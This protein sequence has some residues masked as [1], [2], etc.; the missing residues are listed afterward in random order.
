MSIKVTLSGGIATVLLDRADKLNALSGEMYH[1]FADA[2]G[3]LNGDVEK[4]M[5][6]CGLGMV[7]ADRIE[8]LAAIVDRL[9]T[10]ARAAMRCLQG[11]YQ[12]QA[13]FHNPTDHT[14]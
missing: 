10:E 5:L 9:E 2:F 11:I 8:A 13:L 12:S 7:F 14:G 1:E 3:K 4:A 6:S